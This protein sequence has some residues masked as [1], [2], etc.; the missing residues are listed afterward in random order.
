MALREL[1]GDLPVDFPAAVIVV[2]H[3]PANFTRVL[4][5]QLDRQIALPVREATDGETLKAGRVVVAPGDRHLLVRGDARVELTSGPRVGGHCPSIDVTMQSV[6]QVYGP[7]ASGVVL[8]GMGSDGALGL[9][10]IR[11]R[12]GRTFAQDAASCVVNGM[13]QQAIDRGA[14][15]HVAPP[16]RIAELLLSTP[17]HA[18]ES[19]RW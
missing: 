16:A 2:Q 15:A 1:L 14:V 18:L 11:A 7:R 6:A 10:A 9:A 13:P 17:A 19:K 8:T 4:A 3:M 12:G 5:A